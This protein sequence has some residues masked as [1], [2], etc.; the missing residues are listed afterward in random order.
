MDYY[1]NEFLRVENFLEKYLQ[2]KVQNLISHTL[3]NVMHAKD[4]SKLKE[5]EDARFL[6]LREQL[7]LDKGL[8]DLE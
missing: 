3:N 5:Y 6:E 7:V 1:S 4:K 2:L 8:P